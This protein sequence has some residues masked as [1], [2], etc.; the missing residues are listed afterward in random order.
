MTRH[1][2]V[3]T[4]LYICLM[5]ASPCVKSDY[6]FEAL[7]GHWRCEILV[8]DLDGEWTV[9]GNA[10]WDW[11]VMAEGDAVVDVWRSDSSAGPGVH[12]VSMRVFNRRVG[13]WETARMVASGD[14]RGIQFFA[15]RP[16]APN[17]LTLTGIAGGMANLFQ[18][19]FRDIET[20]AFEWALSVPNGGEA[21]AGEIRRQRC[22]R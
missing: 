13:H 22:H 11:D 17:R 18:V 21:G 5:S 4:I 12:A 14:D 19:T 16:E 3:A 6:H 2:V 9:Q 8:P 15:G 7:S 10:S 20:D 1:P